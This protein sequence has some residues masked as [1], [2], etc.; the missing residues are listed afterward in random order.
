MSRLPAI[1]TE[2]ASPKAKELLEAVQAKLK[3]TPNMT[4]VMA[5]S[6][7]VLQAY[8]SFS[9]ALA[10]GS[11]DPKLREEIA[12]EVGEQNACQ[13]CV[14]AHTAIG[15]MTGLT[16]AEIDAARDARASQP[17]N[18]AA[19]QFAQAIVAKKGLTTDSDVQAVRTAGFSDGEIAEI[20]AHVALNVFTNYFN[21]TAGVE[22]DFPKMALRQSA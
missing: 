16:D 4:R 7:A 19:L 22:V 9:G 14:S 10:G 5:N 20:I 3:I 6:P 2:S 12:L 21:N 8:L 13:Y 15:K 11:L 1:H 18:A 17:K